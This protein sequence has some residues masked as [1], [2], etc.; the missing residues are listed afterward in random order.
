MHTNR[1]KTTWWNSE[2]VVGYPDAHVADAMSQKFVATTSGTP[3]PYA[4]RRTVV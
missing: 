4:L 2:T 3:T 1:I